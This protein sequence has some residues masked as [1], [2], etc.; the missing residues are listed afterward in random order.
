MK[1][2][3][4]NFELQKFA[5]RKPEYYEGLRETPPLGY[6]AALTS[7]GV[8]VSGQFDREAAPG[9]TRAIEEF[10][11]DAKMRTFPFGW[12]PTAYVVRP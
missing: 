6:G 2:S 1:E 9:E 5:A 3:A 10:M 11:P 7:G 4:G 8:M 12:M